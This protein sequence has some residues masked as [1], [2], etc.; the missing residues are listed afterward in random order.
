MPDHGK[1]WARNHQARVVG[2]QRRLLRDHEEQTHDDQQARAQEVRQE[3]PQ[4]R[5]LR[6]EEDQVVVSTVTVS[7]AHTLG[8]D[9][10]KKALS[11]FESDISKYGMK[12]AWSGANA[13]IKGTGASGDVKVTATNVTVVVKLGMM[14][15]VAGVKPD[16]LEKSIEKRLKAALAGTPAPST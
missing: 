16:L 9:A 1:G 4:T 7:Q 6:R 15:K 10:A 13:E 14:A 8:V 5:P 3:A 11:T 12:L 2:R